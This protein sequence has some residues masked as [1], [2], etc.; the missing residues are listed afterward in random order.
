MGR[1][2]S[3]IADKDGVRES[4]PHANRIFFPDVARVKMR[5]SSL[6]D[7][8]NQLYPVSKP[9]AVDRLVAE[10]NCD[11]CER[12]VWTH[13]IRIQKALYDHMTFDVCDLC[14]AIC[15]ELKQKHGYRIY[16]LHHRPTG[17]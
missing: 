13:R 17:F 3:R 10:N 12:R 9:K 16:V 14:F 15:E 11:Q 1:R 7:K 6:Q 8:I 4:D 5:V 2:A